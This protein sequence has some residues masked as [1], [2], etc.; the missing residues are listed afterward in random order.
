MNSKVTPREC[1]STREFKET[2]RQ[3]RHETSPKPSSMTKFSCKEIPRIILFRRRH[4]VFLPRPGPFFEGGHRTELRHVVILLRITRFHLFRGTA[5][6]CGR[7]WLLRLEMTQAVG[8]FGWLVACGS[9]RARGSFFDRSFHPHTP[10]GASLSL[11]LSLT[12]IYLCLY[13]NSFLL[14]LLLLLLFSRNFHAPTLE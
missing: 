14:L 8:C 3:V 2:L 7:S 13:R 11:S 12:G 6:V 9:T 10:F 1:R 5:L 4:V